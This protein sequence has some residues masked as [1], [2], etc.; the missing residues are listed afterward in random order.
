MDVLAG[1]VLYF[2]CHMDFPHQA[3]FEASS[4]V[5]NLGMSGKDSKDTWVMGALET[6][7]TQSTAVPSFTYKLLVASQHQMKGTF[8]E[9]SFGAGGTDAVCHLALGRGPFCPGQRAFKGAAALS[10]AGCLLPGD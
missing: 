5:L 6:P 10:Q 9:H 3:A 2:P 1:N 7:H 4:Q 8:L